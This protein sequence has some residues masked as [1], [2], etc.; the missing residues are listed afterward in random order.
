MHIHP[1]SSIFNRMCL[2]HVIHELLLFQVIAY[3]ILKYVI[4]SM[5]RGLSGLPS[6][7][8]IIF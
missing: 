7:D 8:V 6:A 4:Q 2:V 3:F 1:I 5:L